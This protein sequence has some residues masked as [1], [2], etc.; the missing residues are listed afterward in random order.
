MFY[1]SRRFV[2][3][4]TTV[5]RSSLSLA[6]S[7]QS[8]VNLLNTI[9]TG[10]FLNHDNLRDIKQDGFVV[11]IRDGVELFRRVLEGIL[12]GMRLAGWANKDCGWRPCWMGPTCVLRIEMASKCWRVFCQVCGW[13]DGPNLCPS[14]IIIIIIIII[15]INTNARL[16]ESLKNGKKK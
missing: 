12:P 2:T 4:C 3:A 5:H 9:F 15:I 1:V 16:G 6:K 7:T 14:V 13:L 10:R 11:Q 8:T